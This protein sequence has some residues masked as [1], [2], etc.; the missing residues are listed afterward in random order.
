MGWVG[1]KNVS[2][3][4]SVLRHLRDA[5]P[6]LELFGGTGRVTLHGMARR[7]WWNDAD[8]VL[9]DLAIQIRDDPAGLRRRLEAVDPV[10]LWNGRPK[11]REDWTAEVLLAGSCFTFAG[12]MSGRA[13]ENKRSRS[14]FACWIR[15]LPRTSSMLRDVTITCLDWEEAVPVA[16]KLGAAIYADPPYANARTPYARQVDNEALQGTMEAYPHRVV[17]SGYADNPPRSSRW[18]CVPVARKKVRERL[19]GMWTRDPCVDYP[20]TRIIEPSTTLAQYLY[21]G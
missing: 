8:P 21:G 10:E 2:E 6:V 7:R 1:R 19:D 13:S 14:A 3:V 15:R 9:Y 5:D 16:E 18:R 11:N 20:E 12:R 4:E 17:L